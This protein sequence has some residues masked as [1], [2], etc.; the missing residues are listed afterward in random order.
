[1]L[2]NR[3]YAASLAGFLLGTLVIFGIVIGD[4]HLCKKPSDWSVWGDPVFKNQGDCVSFVESLTNPSGSL[5][6]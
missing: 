5:N 2:V 3:R 6:L 4:K 1:M